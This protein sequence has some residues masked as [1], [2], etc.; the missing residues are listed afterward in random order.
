MPSWVAYDQGAPLYYYFPDR[1]NRLGKAGTA[2]LHCHVDQRGT[3]SGCV[4]SG[5]SPPDVGFA[6]AAFVLAKHMA[7]DVT[8][9]A[10][11]PVANGE[12]DITLSFVRDPPVIA[13]PAVVALKAPTAAQVAAV[14]PPGAEGQGNGKVQ[15]T[16]QA[17]ADGRL[18]RC[19]VASETPHGL[20]F[21]DAARQL[22]SNFLVQVGAASPARPSDF[23]SINF[24]FHDPDKHQL[25]R[26]VGQ[27]TWIESFDPTHL[28]AVYPVRALAAGVKAG[29]ATVACTVA[30]DGRLFSCAPLDESPSGLGFGDAAL[31][32]AAELRMSAWSP[33][34]EPTAGARIRLPVSLLAPGAPAPPGSTSAFVDNLNWLRRPNADDLAQVYPIAAARSGMG[35]EARIECTVSAAGLLAGCKVLA[36]SPQGAGFGEAALALA[37]KFAMKTVT[38]SGRPVAGASV[39]IPI[40]FQTPTSN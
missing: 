21:G 29:K 9:E 18:R 33:T 11:A 28:A 39:V 31:K 25:A 40:R 6:Q 30:D 15:L 16:C 4:V 38:P 7:V 1:A 34:G 3:L 2:T 35:G 32:V 23:V 10:Q 22:T 13:R 19:S 14:F 37:P 26:D 24:A 8:P 12:V 17:L 5:E 27:P 36:E 20:G